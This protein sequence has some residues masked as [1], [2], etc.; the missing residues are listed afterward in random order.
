MTLIFF[1]TYHY[2][3]VFPAFVF[4]VDALRCFLR[5]GRVEG[6]TYAHM[7]RVWVN[8]EL[9]DIAVLGNGHV[10]FFILLF[11]ATRGVL[12]LTNLGALFFSRGRR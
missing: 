3:H 6:E 7:L 1:P 10:R 2:Y 5:F 12:M 8:P 11:F 9:A 4:V